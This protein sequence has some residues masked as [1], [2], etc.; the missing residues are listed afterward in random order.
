MSAEEFQRRR[1][2]RIG[3]WSVGILAG[4]LLLVFIVL[5]SSQP[6]DARANFTDAKKYVSAGRMEDA[7]SAV[8]LAINARPRFADAYRLRASIHRAMDQPELA[9]KDISRVVE[10]EPN[11]AEN[12]RVRAQAYVDL[13]Q[14]RNALADFDMLIKL[15]PSA[16]AYNDRGVCYR[17]LGDNSRAVEDFSNAIRLEPSVEGYLQRGMVLAAM[18]DHRR[19]IDDFN[20]ALEI[21]AD[22]PAV[23]RARASSRDALGD[24]AGAAADRAKAQ[25]LETVP[26]GAGT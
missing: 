9:L 16:R 6:A 14:Y 17:M 10:L 25:E 24:R 11:V 26:S 15:A 21:R 7:L 4:M 18:G 19:A 13:R 2:K 23:Y 1:W 22:M 20:R 3:V 12:Y 5:K 8:N